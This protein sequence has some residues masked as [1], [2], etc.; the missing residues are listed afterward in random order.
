MF[1]SDIYH[2]A[3]LD[4]F[5]RGNTQKCAVQAIERVCERGLIFQNAIYKGVVNL[6]ESQMAAPS[7]AVLGIDA[8]HDGFFLLG[9]SL[10]LKDFNARNARQQHAGVAYDPH[11]QIFTWE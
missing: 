4:R 5:F 2:C 8:M 10:P 6:I 3:P 7:F 11:L 9:A 1:S